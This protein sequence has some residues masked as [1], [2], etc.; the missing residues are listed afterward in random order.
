MASC[1]DVRLV[2][3]G[4]LAYYKY[5]RTTF[6]RTINTHHNYRTI[7]HHCITDYIVRYKFQ[8]ADNVQ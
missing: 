2:K 1:N 3:M 5:L 6:T 7:L 4:Q 8:S